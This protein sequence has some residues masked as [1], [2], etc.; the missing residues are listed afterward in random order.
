[1]VKQALIRPS[2]TRLI[3]HRGYVSDEAP[4]NGPFSYACRSPSLFGVSVFS[5]K[6]GMMTLMMF[7]RVK[8]RPTDALSYITTVQCYID[9]VVS[10][11]VVFN[12][13]LWPC[14]Y[15]FWMGGRCCR[16]SPWS[17]STCV[18][19]AICRHF[20]IRYGRDTSMTSQAFRGLSVFLCRT[21]F[22]IYIRRDNPIVYEIILGR[23]FRF[24][25]F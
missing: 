6:R 14:T 21:Y 9:I 2:R 10:I 20:S 4:E 1:M 11:P 23:T 24:W 19:I 16:R 13:M 22:P 18:D 15:L 12:D 7:D 25:V 3:F 5:Q 17:P 8:K